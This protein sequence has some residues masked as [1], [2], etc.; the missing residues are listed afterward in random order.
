[1]F[2]S[3]RLIKVCVTYVTAAVLTACGGGD[4]ASPLTPPLAAGGGSGGTNTGATGS[5]TGSIASIAGDYPVAVSKFDCSAGNKNPGTTLELQA[6]GSCKVTTAAL[7]GL[8]AN[9]TFQRDLLPE[10]RYTLRITFD[11]AM[12]LLQGT[13]SKAK[14]TCPPNGLCRVDTVAIFTTYSIAGG[15]AAVSGGGLTSII[16]DNSST[17]KKVASGTVY[18]IGNVTVTGTPTNPVGSAETGILIFASP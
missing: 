3:S 2:Q 14:V 16:I 15:S 10:G 1:M 6:N 4:P 18:A 12:D 5:T 8:P 9:T 11:G 7:G 13:A 17:P